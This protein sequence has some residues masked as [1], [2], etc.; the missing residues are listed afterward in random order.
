VKLKRYLVWGSYDGGYAA[1]ELVEDVEPDG[2]W[3]K[4]ADVTELEEKV[5]RLEAEKAAGQH[6]LESIA[7]SIREKI[8]GETAD[9]VLEY[10]GSIAMAGDIAVAK[11]RSAS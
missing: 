1:D 6:S 2:E 3:V 9:V 11:F 8:D 7:R 4:Y 10:I 5:V